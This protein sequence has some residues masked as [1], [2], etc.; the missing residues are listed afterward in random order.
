M[1]II[2]E[3]ELEK[4]GE[5]LK[6]IQNEKLR[7]GIGE[8]VVNLYQSMETIELSEVFRH[9][10]KINNLDEKIADDLE[11]DKKPFLKLPEKVRYGFLTTGKTVY[12]TSLQNMKNQEK[13]KA[14]VESVES[15]VYSARIG[16]ETY[17]VSIMQYYVWAGHR[18]SYGRYEHNSEKSKELTEKY[19]HTMLKHDKEGEF[20]L[21][22]A[23]YLGRCE[24]KEKEAI[25]TKYTELRKKYFAGDE[26][27]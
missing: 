25:S 27:E 22:F 13:R 9:V 2:S 17:E 19:I 24:A 10:L 1:K 20:K 7:D 21:G 18:N 11:E 14:N 8:T 15:L 16:Y 3:R 5:C 12:V 6:Q 4:L 23:N 26:Q